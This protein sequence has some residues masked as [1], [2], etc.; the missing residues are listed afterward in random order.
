MTPLA[1]LSDRSF[2]RL[3]LVSV[4]VACCGAG[5]GQSPVTLDA[6]RALGPA[7]VTG[8]GTVAGYAEFD[9]AG[10]PT[11]IGV[12]ISAG[13]LEGLP[14]AHS[15]GHRCFDA[16]GDG[17]MDMMSECANWHEFVL[18][19]P[20]QASTREDIPFKWVL[21]NWNPYGHI[22]PGV[23]DSPH[24][25]IHFYMA[26]IEKVFALQRGTCGIEFMR[27]DQYELAIQPLPSNYMPP[28]YEHVG[29]AAPAMGNHLIDT[30][31][32]EFHGEVFNRAWVYGTYAGQMT[33]Y[34]EM[35]A[36]SYLAS[37][38][39]TCFDIKMPPAVNATGYYPTRSCIRYD[40]A[41]D[42]YTVSMEQFI[43]RDASPPQ[44]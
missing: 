37:Q 16:D 39:D 13:A 40:Q 35:V 33:F 19:L 3:W 36:H 2:M 26:P 21:Y 7:V 18:P 30:T 12:V 24:F 29:A 25:D 20:S 34:E 15:D 1:P 23:F 41:A 6:G 28:D 11:A 9:D 31:A 5:C 10:T 14:T 32:P 17:A 27:C 44:T 4:L 22:P 43:K 42:E 8:N 38:P